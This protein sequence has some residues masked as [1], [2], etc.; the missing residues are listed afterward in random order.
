VTAKVSILRQTAKYFREKV[1]LCIVFRIPQRWEV[2]QNWHT[3]S[4]KPTL[5]GMFSSRLCLICGCLH[6][7][8]WDE[9]PLG[10]TDASIRGV[11][12]IGMKT[13]R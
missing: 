2:Y 8:M 5:V 3:F 7:L 10:L 11:C 1:I 9:S 4:Q 12:G 6:P 13:S